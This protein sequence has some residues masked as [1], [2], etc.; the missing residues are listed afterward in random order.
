[1]KKILLFLSL[2]I[3]SI[4][5]FAQTRT[6][7]GTVV[8][9][10]KNEPLVGVT[11]QVKGSPTATQTDVNGKYALKTTNMQNVVVTVKYVG[12]AYQERTLRVGENNF[13]VRMVPSTENLEDVVVVGYGTQKK[14]SLTGAV[15]QV[16]IKAIED[17][18]STNLAATLRGQLPNV[19][20]AGGSERPGNNATITIRNP[21]FY[22]KDGKT[23]PLYIIDDIQRTVSDFNLLDP[24]EVESISILK[25]ASAAIYGILGANGVIVVK[26]KRGKA[27]AAK[28]SYSG[29]YGL[30]DAVMLPKMMNGLQQA[31]YLN[32]NLQVANNF[33]I[34]PNG[35]YTNPSTGVTTRLTAY[36]SP[37]EL[38]HFANNNYDHLRDAWQV[39]YITRHALNV[40]GGSD[41]A[42][43][44]AGGSY[45]QQNSNFDGVNTNKLTFRASSDVRVANG[46]KVSTSVSGALGDNKRYYFKQGSESLNNDFI[47]LQAIP[48]FRPMYYNGLPVLQSSNTG[49]TEGAHFFEVQR[50]NN[51]TS[52]RSTMLNFLASIEYEV[53]HVKGL[54]A[55]LSYNRN[56][57]NDFSKQYGSRY[58]LYNFEGL[59]EN[60]HIVG[61]NIVST[62]TARNGDVVRFTPGYL[63]V[64]QFNGILSYANKFGKHDIS[65]IA[66]FE[67]QEN[68]GES[69]AAS[70]EGT[71]VGGF[72]NMNFATGQ[73]A[74][75]QANGRILNYGRLAYAARL[76]YAY[77]NKYLVEVSLRTDANNNFAPGKEYGFFPSG[78]LGWVISEEGFF[79]NS[80]KF[81]DFL[82][83][84][85]SVG[86][87]G[88]DSSKPF[89]YQENYKLETGK[90]AVFGGNN[91]RGNSFAPNIAIAN[92]NTRWDDNLTTNFGIDAQFLRNRLSV[93]L[94]GFFS[95]RYNLLS[96]LTS[97]VPATIGVAPPTENFASVNTFGYEL[98]F[99]WRDKIGKDFTYNFS[100]FFAW[101]DNKL[102]NVDQP[103]GDVGTYLDKNG[104]SSD[105]GFFG[106][107]YL[108]MWR[109]QAE[110]DAFAAANPGY[111]IKGQKPM[112]GMLYYQD[113]RGPRDASGKFTAPDGKINEEDQD[114][115]TNKQDNHYS[116]GLNFGAGYKGITLA[117]TMGMSYG[118][119]GSYEGDSRKQAT[120]L[121][122]RPEFWSDHWT[123]EN[124]NAK[125][126]SP[127]YKDTYD[128]PSSFWYVSSYTFRINNINL[129]Y[130]IPASFTKKLGIGSAKAFLV[131]TNPVNFYNPFTYR[132]NGTPYN[133]Y[134]N[135]K[136]LSLGLNV[137]F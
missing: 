4:S 11:I 38:A 110:A 18:P 50:L 127:Y 74:T 93:T 29:S 80:V 134:P 109:T 41:K 87:L 26:T 132:D 56:I 30:S 60:K 23:D 54:K 37:D 133:V 119:Q 81:V 107:H 94:D 61:G 84:R 10:D 137:G 75:D 12:Y 33:A 47:S 55:T 136:T 14:A 19:N 57:N 8:S 82:K 89:L 36:Y 59:G 103:L 42:T 90:A 43:Y 86:L 70:R 3:V 2:C 64:Y 85:G 49:T 63:D 113:V 13:D 25:D 69:L 51:Y 123:P 106:Y 27:G 58:T 15:A 9:S 112:A 5:V 105:R 96:A 131:A 95:H 78:S 101:N 104:Y 53:P 122:N 83:V 135:L 108:G 1:M 76:N 92:A 65:A 128:L 40:S 88:N 52:Q 99:S 71:L 45:T 125:Y 32:D 118:G 24:S 7:T 16:N 6:I 124:I 67:Q 62:P 91:D 111:T 98:S 46:L 35:D 20:V 66:L 39:S 22:A 77:D 72:D 48:Q 120:A 126:P 115:L 116:L 79:K 100:P 102:L 44:F 73:Q 21:V 97:S 28:I 129:G 117:V 34:K 68:H 121:I 130:N 17:I 31:T 114:Y